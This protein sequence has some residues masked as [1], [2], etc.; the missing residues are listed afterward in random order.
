MTEG[1]AVSDSALL[2]EMAV[3]GLHFNKFLLQSRGSCLSNL[4]LEHSIQ[5]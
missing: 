3:S 2:D 4:M 1:F 5:M